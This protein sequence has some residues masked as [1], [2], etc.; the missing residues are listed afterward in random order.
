MEIGFIFMG[1]IVSGIVGGIWVKHWMMHLTPTQKYVK[2][3][4]KAKKHDKAAWE[5]FEKTIY[6]NRR[7]AEKKGLTSIVW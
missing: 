7:E 2:M 4:A 1:A 5:A 3:A 6:K